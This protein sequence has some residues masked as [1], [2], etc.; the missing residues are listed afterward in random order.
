M[1]Q[2]SQVFF[3]LNKSETADSLPA[4]WEAE[5]HQLNLTSD[6]PRVLEQGHPEPE[7]EPD[8]LLIGQRTLAALFFLYCTDTSNRKHLLVSLYDPAGD[9]YSEPV[10][11]PPSQPTNQASKQASKQPAAFSLLGDKSF[12]TSDDADFTPQCFKKNDDGWMDGLINSSLSTHE[13]AAAGKRWW[14]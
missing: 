6:P 13:S 3:Q 8:P 7:P 12:R 14:W 9:T 2:T 1:L 4:R 5:C 11:I 10:L